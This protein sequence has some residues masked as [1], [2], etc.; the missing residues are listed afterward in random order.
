MHLLS[1]SLSLSVDDAPFPGKGR[2]CLV[3]YKNSLLDKLCPHLLLN[4]G[5]LGN[6]IICHSLVRLHNQ[7]NDILPRHRSLIGVVVGRRR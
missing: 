1:L 4:L 7:I 2:V 5:I 3:V 6:P